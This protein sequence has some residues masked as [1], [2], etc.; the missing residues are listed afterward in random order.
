MPPHPARPAQPPI[1]PVANGPNL[2]PAVHLAGKLAA[3]RERHGVPALAAV[4]VRDGGNTV[5]ARA[6]GVRKWDA[7][8]TSTANAVRQ[9]DVFNIGSVTK[10]FTGY[11]IAHLVQ[12]RADF[13][14]TTTIGDVFPELASPA[15]RARYRVR[16]EYLGR[17]VEQL[18]SH[19][20]GLPYAPANG[21][22]MV[23]NWPALTGAFQQEYA[24]AASLDARRYNYLLT[25]LQDAPEPAPGPAIVYGGGSIICAA[26]AERL[27]GQRYEDLMAQLVFG[28]LGMTRSGFGRLARNAVPDGVWEHVSDPSTGAI[29]PSADAIL[30]QIDFTRTAPPARRSRRRPTWDA[31]SPPT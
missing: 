16:Q 15:F 13:A 27:T 9:D 4:L 2:G 14:W 6:G 31:S 3:V 7:S 1:G 17:T 21:Y 12:Q 26:M 8:H 24:T 29:T 19:N 28:P 11:L 20:A 22:E 10:P 5:V 25:S 30:P 23:A 18:M